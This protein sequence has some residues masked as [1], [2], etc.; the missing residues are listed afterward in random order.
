M[1][2][3]SSYNGDNLLIRWLPF[4]GK[5]GCISGSDGEA[6]ISLNNSDKYSDCVGIVNHLRPT[7]D[8][9]MILTPVKTY[10]I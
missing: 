5:H 3:R 9:S 2:T 6:L 10:T 7:I 1:R 4:I 8:I